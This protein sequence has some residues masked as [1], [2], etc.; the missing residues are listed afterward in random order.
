MATLFSHSLIKRS[1]IIWDVSLVD[2]LSLPARGE[3]LG[4]K[5]MA[6]C[7]GVQMSFGRRGQAQ[8]HECYCVC[9][10]AEARCAYLGTTIHERTRACQIHKKTWKEYWLLRW[11]LTVGGSI[12]GAGRASLTLAAHTCRYLENVL[13]CGRQG[14]WK[15]AQ[16]YTWSS[17]CR[18]GC[19]YQI[20]QTGAHEETKCNMSICWRILK[21]KHAHTQPFF[22]FI[23]MIIMVKQHPQTRG[24]SMIAYYLILRGYYQINTTDNRCL[25]AKPRPCFPASSFWKGTDTPIQK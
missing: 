15:H 1:R 24:S 18:G 25:S 3:S 8:K 14:A 16:T 5:V 17:Q 9:A 13:L 4:Q 20:G 6:S 22:A 19:I 11:F 2:V 12:S 7:K 23:H 21:Q 10:E